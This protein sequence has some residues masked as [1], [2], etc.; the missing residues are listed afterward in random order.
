MA[1]CVSDNWALIYAQQL[2]VEEKLPLH[3]CVC[4]VVPKSELSTLRHYSFMLN[5][6]KEVAQVCQFLRVMF[7][8]CQLANKY[9]KLY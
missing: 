8:K 9:I 5:G 3:I 4:L 1:T 2:A 6:L 7:L